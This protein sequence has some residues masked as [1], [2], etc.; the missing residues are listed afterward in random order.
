MPWTVENVRLGVQLSVAVAIAYFVSMAFG[1]PEGLWAVMSALIVVRAR[2]G[3]TVNEGWA[4]MKGTILGVLCGLLGV[5]L[6]DL[7][8]GITAIT[9]GTV[10]LLAFVGGLSSNLRSAPIAA[11]IVLAGGAIAGHSVWQVAGLRIA[12]I[13]IGISA[14]TVVSLMTLS[15]RSA[16]RFEQS[17][18]SLLKEMSAQTRQ[19]LNVA[20]AA[21]PGHRAASQKI[22]ARLGRLALL[23]Q[24]AE[25]ERR[26]LFL[27]TDVRSTNAAT[28]ARRARLLALISEDWELLGRIFALLPQRQKD[29]L[30]LEVSDGVSEALSHAANTLQVVDVSADSPLEMLAARLKTTSGPSADPDDIGILLAAPVRL[31]IEDLRRF[32]EAATRMVT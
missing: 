23:A 19:S 13:V 25:T 4:R 5:W 8:F 1:L 3:S 7:G 30:W 31:L 10:A 22:K 6:H 15:F 14:G 11:L 29:P 21:G 32:A 17:V 24:S 9:L 28:Y 16:S 20:G 27:R 12:E 26:F 18:A 2:T